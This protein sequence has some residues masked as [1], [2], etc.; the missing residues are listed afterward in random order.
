MKPL[1][2]IYRTS[3]FEKKTQPE[4]LPVPCESHFSKPCIVINPKDKSSSCERIRKLTNRSI[5]IC[6][7][8]GWEISKPKNVK[9]TLFVD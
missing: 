6:E 7:K 1:F 8:C 5:E 9:R 2:H 3:G 4:I